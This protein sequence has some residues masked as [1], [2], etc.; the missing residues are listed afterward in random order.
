MNKVNDHI[1][2]ELAPSVQKL[3]LELEIDS[4]NLSI[5]IKY[6]DSKDSFRECVLLLNM[7][8]SYVYDKVRLNDFIKNEKDFQS[9]TYT[10]CVDNKGQ[11]YKVDILWFLV[12]MIPYWLSLVFKEESLDY[13]ID[14]QS[15]PIGWRTIHITI[16]KT[17]FIILLKWDSSEEEELRA[18]ML[19]ERNQLWIPDVNC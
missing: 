12:P 11:G 6:P 19:H 17:Q 13:I 16:E 10:F 3:Y 7:I 18:K 8:S 1:L 14:K 9:K 5:P 2:N 15:P 4:N